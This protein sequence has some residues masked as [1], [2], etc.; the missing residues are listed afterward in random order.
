MTAPT[1]TSETEADPD[2]AARGEGSGETFDVIVLCAGST[3][4]NVAGY[5]RDNDLTVAVIEA[6]LVGGEC[7]Y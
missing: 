3:G 5:A 2:D 6:E 1:M 7:S 4:T